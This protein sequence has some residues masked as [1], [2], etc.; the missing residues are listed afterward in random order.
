MSGA[1]TGSAVQSEGGLYTLEQ[2]RRKRKGK[3]QTPNRYTR[4]RARGTPAKAVSQ[5]H[6]H[7]FTLT[8]AWPTT[9]TS[10]I[11]RA[12][13]LAQPSASP[14]ALHDTSAHFGWHQCGHSTL[15][16][17]TTFTLITKWVHRIQRPVGRPSVQL[18]ASRLRSSHPPAAPHAWYAPTPYHK[19][20]TCAS[21]KN[22]REV[23]SSISSP[24]RAS[25]WP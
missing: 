12:T 2:L 5:L 1:R 14:V 8:L 13:T 11:T 10:R 25:R 19:H 24:C 15:T 16:R 21:R 3:L 20:Q 17:A 22:K 4:D 18:Q 7:N 6:T 9:P 23:A